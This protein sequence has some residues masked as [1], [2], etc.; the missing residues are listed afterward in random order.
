MKIPPARS[1][2]QLTIILEALATIR[3]LPTG[4]MAPQ[5][6][7]QARQFPLGT[8]LVIVAALISDEMVEAIV[9]LKGQGYKLVIVHVGSRKC[10]D[11]PEG[12]LVHSLGDYLERMELTSAFQPG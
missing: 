10:P 12:I 11:L 9:K 2:E 6:T 1:P 5:L 7:Q 3:P 4:P 8:T